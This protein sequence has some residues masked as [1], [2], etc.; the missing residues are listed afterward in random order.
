MMLINEFYNTNN[1]FTA[2]KMI[3]VVVES[4]DVRE[5]EFRLIL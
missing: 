3:Y 5:F 1:Q 2:Q 4:E